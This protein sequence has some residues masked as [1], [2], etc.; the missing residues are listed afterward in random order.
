MININ[1]ESISLLPSFLAMPTE[2]ISSMKMM[3]GACLRA[4][5]KMSRTMRAP[6]PMYFCTSSVPATRI[7]E[8]LV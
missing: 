7:N 6:S 2:S 8:Q 3:E 4:K 5:T 1:N